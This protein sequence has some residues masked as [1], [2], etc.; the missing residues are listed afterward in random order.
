[1]KPETTKSFVEMKSYIMDAMPN[2]GHLVS[3]NMIEKFY[4]EL[5]AEEKYRE[6]RI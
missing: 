2:T 6:Q 5:K 4:A 3:D 1:M